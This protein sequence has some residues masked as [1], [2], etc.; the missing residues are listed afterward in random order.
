MNKYSATFADGTTITRGTKR[1]YAVAWRATWT[2]TGGIKMVQ[3]GFSASASKVKAERP[4]LHLEYRGMSS[5]DRAN[6]RRLNAE[7]AAKCGY[8]VEIIPA[9]LEA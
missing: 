3:T 2:T 8:K 5:N 9:V 1:T 4:F 6:A 7:Y